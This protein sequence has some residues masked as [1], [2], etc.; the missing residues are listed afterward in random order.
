MP[1]PCRPEP[2]TLTL[3][4]LAKERHPKRRVILANPDEPRAGDYS[5]GIYDKAH[6][7]FGD[8]ATV[9]YFRGQLRGLRG[10]RVT[11]KVNGVRVDEDGESHRFVIRRTFTLNRYSDVFGP[12]S[13]YGSAIHAQREAHS[14][15]TLVT[16]S[17]TIEPATDEDDDYE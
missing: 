13:A 8:K 4:T 15:D 7:V 1:R 12:G 14:D 11:M 9:D 2:A 10:E 6:P 16:H 17:L 5:Y 3:P